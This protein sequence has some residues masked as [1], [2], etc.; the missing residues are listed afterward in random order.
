MSHLLLSS[1]LVLALARLA[2]GGEKPAPL[3][4][5]DVIAE[6]QAADLAVAVASDA[7]NRLPAAYPVASTN[8]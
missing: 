3:R 8:S 4:L 6:A 1:A 2:G 5:D 7:R